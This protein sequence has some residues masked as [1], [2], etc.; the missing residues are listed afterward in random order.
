MVGRFP[1]SQ[2]QKEQIYLGKLGGRSLLEL[3]ATVGCTVHCARKWWRVG[4]DTGLAG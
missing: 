4:R 1:L 2:A 3:A